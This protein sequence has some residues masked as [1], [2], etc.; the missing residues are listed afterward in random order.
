MRGIPRS[1]EKLYH[2]SLLEGHAASATAVHVAIGRRAVQHH[3]HVEGAEGPAIVRL[4]DLIRSKVPGADAP[5]GVI[6]PISAPPPSPAADV[7][8]SALPPA[9]GP[10]RELV[11]NARAQLGQGLA[12]VGSGGT[13]DLPALA[14]TAAAFVASL[15][16]DESLMAHALDP[17]ETGP[18]LAR[19]MTNVAIFAIKIGMC[20]GF[21][22]EKLEAAGLAGLVHDVGLVGL[23]GNLLDKPQG[24]SAEEQQLLLQHPEVGARIIRAAGPEYSWLATVVLQEHER[25]DGSGYPKGLRGDD[26]HELAKVVGIADVYEALTHPRPYRRRMSPLDAVKEIISLERRTFPDWVLKGLIR[27]LS[28]FPVGS[29]VRLN[30]KEIGRVRATNP[31]F[32]LRPVV[33]ILAGPSAD[34]SAGPRVVDLSQNSLL[35]IVDSYTAEE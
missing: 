1:I 15:Q 17:R 10:A 27:G 2:L 24:L 32:P 4:A 19:H 26:I 28:T 13:L 34:R 7:L 29:L 22:R 16:A 5:D 33:E 35:F 20:V 25:E 11:D 21:P 9:A 23:P 14:H 3:Q 8:A 12:A 31:A 30:S 6:P 18:D